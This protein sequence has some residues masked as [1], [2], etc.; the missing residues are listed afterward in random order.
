MKAG[1]SNCSHITRWD[2][3]V[4]VER[5]ILCGRVRPDVGEEDE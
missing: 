1:T 2:D 4:G 3:D 5:C